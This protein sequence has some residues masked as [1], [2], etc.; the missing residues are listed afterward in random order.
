MFLKLFWLYGGASVQPKDGS[1]LFLFPAGVKGHILVNT[2]VFHVPFCDTARL[3]IPAAEAVALTG[4]IGGS[5]GILA[6][7]VSLP[8]YQIVLLRATIGAAILGIMLLA[9][10]KRLTSLAYKGELAMA[11]GAGAVLGYAEPLSAVL[12]GAA[13]LG[14][15]MLP[16]QMAGAGLIV[17]GALARPAGG[18]RAGPRHQRDVRHVRFRAH[19]RAR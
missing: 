8:S 4:G 17:L 2:V 19:L 15:S 9:S 16:I 18:L 5:N 11:A 1:F 13:V 10:R 3:Y 6:S 7:A 14:E 12:F